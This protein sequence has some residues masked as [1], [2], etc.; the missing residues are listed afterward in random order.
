M[1]TTS[2][3]PEP[4]L[5]LERGRVATAF[6][7]I[8]SVLADDPT[9]KRC[10]LK[11][12]TYRDGYIQSEAVKPEP[13]VT[14]LPFLRMGLANTVMAWE[15]EASHQFDPVII[16]QLYTAGPHEFD[17]MNLFEAVCH[18]LW[19]QDPDQRELVFT[20]FR[21][22]PG[23]MKGKFAS[24]FAG[25]SPIGMGRHGLKATFQM[26]ISLSVST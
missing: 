15:T 7:M 6:E 13:D 26:K 4:L 17:L 12:V 24:G 25:M 2:T 16:C 21:S 14:E 3:T 1:P 20:R 23:L 9:L 19:P 18:A 5:P 8:R 22:V 11:I 10:N